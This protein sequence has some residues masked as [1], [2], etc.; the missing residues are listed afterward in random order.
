MKRLSEPIHFTRNYMI[1]NQLLILFTCFLTLGHAQTLQHPVIWTTQD[2]KEDILKLI[3]ETQWARAIVEGVHTIVDE[4]VEKHQTKPTLIFDQ[5]PE[6]SDDDN[7]LELEVATV[8]QH[9]QILQKAAYAALLYY[10]TNQKPY[11]QFAAD[12]LWYYA[13]E[14]APREPHNTS[15]CGNAFYDPRTSYVQ[16]AIAYDFI[17]N[18]LRKSNPKVYSTMEKGLINYDHATMQKAIL[19]MVG[20]TLQEYGLPDEYG[21]RISNHPILTG[22][23]ALFGILCVEDDT[24]RER[25]FNVFWE[26]G[27]KHQNSFKNTL[28]PMF[29]EQGI[30]PE[31]TSYSF[32]GNV[33]MMLNIID[34]IKPEMNAI[35]NNMHILDGNFL[36]DNLRLPDR[37]FVT[38][39]DSHRGHDGTASLYR[40]TLDIA[41]RRGFTAYEKKAT[42]ALRQ[43]FTAY[44]TNVVIGTFDNYS[45]FTRLLW[46]SSIPEKVEGKIDFQKPTVIIEHAGIALQGNYVEENNQEYG[47]CGIIGGA[48]YVHSHLTGIGMELYGAGYVMAPSAGLPTSVAQRRIPL[49]EHYFRLYAG[50]NT[51]IVN[52]TSHGLDK[53]SW[54]PRAHVWQNT[55]VNVAAEPAHLEDPKN[56]NFSFATQFLK[57]E[58]NN[59]EQQRTLST[60]R[61]SPT[62]AYY[63]DMFR[64]KSLDENKFHDYIYHNLGDK[65]SITTIEGDKFK[66]NETDRYNN[67]IGDVVHSPGW[68]YF[69]NTRVTDE[70]SDAV[71]VRYDI[72]KNKK[73]MH[74]FVPGGITRAYTQ[75]LA[76]PSRDVKNGYTGK[77]TQVLA[78]RQNGEAWKKPYISIFEP[79]ANSQSSVQSVDHLY[80]EGIV[81]GAKVTSQV[82]DQQIVDYIICHDSEDQEFSL[83]A[84]DLCFKGRFAIARS[85]TQNGET[86]LELYIGEGEKLSFK[87]QSITSE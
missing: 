10:L 65:A 56:E 35:D 48:H 73:Y 71:Y 63:F 61:T 45:V 52:G 32:M 26:E 43:S 4:Q 7:V 70:V 27:T 11:A 13:E 2:Q 72:K 50:N 37:R 82:G 17:Y 14:L 77:K 18:Y 8:H 81:I 83:P 44:P 41:K 67:D 49:H 20:N 9:S 51:V 23:G 59:A 38:Y 36:F 22:P 46:G 19:N 54:K 55:V 85:I 24:E 6:I 60:I 33:T 78:I 12:I 15:I 84:V 62:T 1:K 30:W 86:A 16:F 28:L 3:E 68:R 80:S 39:G 34:R 76:P 66:L 57:D 21:G 53:G 58:V 5:I 75:A 74:Q 47:L 79:S 40:F 87:D 29:G 64:S 42:I 69:E 25:L 31:S